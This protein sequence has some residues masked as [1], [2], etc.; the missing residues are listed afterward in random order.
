ML[1]TDRRPGLINKGTATTQVRTHLGRPERQILPQRHPA[2]DGDF[3]GLE[4]WDLF[5]GFENLQGSLVQAHPSGL[6][7]LVTCSHGGRWWWL[8]GCDGLGCSEEWSTVVVGGCG[9]QLWLA[10][11]DDMEKVLVDQVQNLWTYKG[12][13]TN[14]GVLGF[15]SRP[16]PTL[17]DATARPPRV[18]LA[19]RHTCE[20]VTCRLRLQL[21]PD[22]GTNMALESVLTDSVSV[23]RECLQRASDYVPWSKLCICLLYGYLIGL[24]PGLKT[25]IILKESHSY[26]EILVTGCSLLIC[27]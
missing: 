10:V 15:H 5:E 16:N 12:T 13:P 9:W 1:S 6:A 27:P 4:V 8:C 26:V 7:V 22:Q 17:K 21:E 11:V 18:S 20:R 19:H 23:Q 3:L 2:D 14:G 24:L 25:D